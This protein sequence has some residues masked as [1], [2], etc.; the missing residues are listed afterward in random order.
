MAR[1]KPSLTIEERVECLEKTLGAALRSIDEL[2]DEVEDL[3]RAGE[4]DE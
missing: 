2:T 4:G 3:R 1:K